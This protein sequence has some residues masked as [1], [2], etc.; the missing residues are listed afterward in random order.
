MRPST[1]LS[2]L[3]LASNTTSAPPTPPKGPVVPAA[4]LNTPAPAEKEKLAT[5]PSFSGLVEAVKGAVV[6]VEVRQ[7]VKGAQ[8][9]RGGGTGDSDEDEL[10]R[11]FFGV[12]PKQPQ[13]QRGAGSGFI[14]REDGLVLTNNHVVQGAEEIRVRL[15][16]GRTFEAKVLGTDPLTDLA[17][18]QLK[19]G[20]IKDLPV[21]KLGDSD[22][23][24]VG[25]WV[26]AIGNPFGLATSVSAG[27]VSAKERNIGAGPYDDF[28]QTDAAINP[29]NSGGPLFNL[30]GEV[31]GI[32]TAIV[33]GGTGIGFAV[34]S[35]FVKVELPQLEKGVVQRGWLG[36]SIQDLTPELAKAL[37]VSEQHG[38]VVSDV[39][40]GTPAKSAG[41]KPDDV[42]IGLNGGKVVSAMALSRAVG[43]MKPGEKV[44][45]TVMHGGEKRDVKIQLGKRPDLEG[46]SKKE[47]PAK[48]EPQE[49]FG[50]A[51]QDS[52]DGQGAVITE[53]ETGSPAERAGLVAGMTVIEADNV[54]VHNAAD[55]LRVLSKAKT[56][57]TLLLR[58][59]VE[60]GKILRALPVS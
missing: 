40:S 2:V 18:V 9:G 48:E 26:V 50:V 33:G 30:Q 12:N 28:L 31:V 10:L 55:L 38:A 5:L 46:V 17:L 51:F 53:V 41:L 8:P 45:L 1:L 27:I 22:A 4:A 25:D 60:G 13:V 44:T 32:N 24:N 54:P 47:A 58:L 59:K 42:I 49:K 7:R 11:R 36:I 52:P 43:F 23:L 20:T 57:Q 35:S 37:K 14:I 15:D 29:G 3:V 56:G 6:N 39:P 16:D 21:L 34:P 19:D